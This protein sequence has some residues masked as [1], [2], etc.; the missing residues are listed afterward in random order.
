[1]LEVGK[2][3]VVSGAAFISCLPFGAVAGTGVW[4]L[5][6]TRFLICNFLVCIE[7]GLALHENIWTLKLLFEKSFHNSFDKVYLL[8][9][10]DGIYRRHCILVS[11]GSS[12]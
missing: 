3:T 7:L 8:F 10:R 2:E 11:G 6:I 12:G 5:H 9:D 1:M 4:Y